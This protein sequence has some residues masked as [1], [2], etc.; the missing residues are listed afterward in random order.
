[1]S[2]YWDRSLFL[3]KISHRRTSAAAAPAAAHLAILLDSFRLVDLLLR[4]LPGP[5]EEQIHFA[6]R[7]V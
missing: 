4:N 6:I 1:M 5:G 2:L 7:A 3:R